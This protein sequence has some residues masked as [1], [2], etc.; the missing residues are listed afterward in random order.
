MR[1]PRTTSD[2]PLQPCVAA[3]L[4][5]VPNPP[6]QR[7]QWL[8]LETCFLQGRK[9]E[10]PWAS[11]ATITILPQALLSCPLLDLTALPTHTASAPDQTPLPA[12]AGA[13]QTPRQAGVS[14]YKLTTLRTGSGGLGLPQLSQEASLRAAVVPLGGPFTAGTHTSLRAA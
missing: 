3:F 4:M 9:P 11:S 2:G 7:T 1:A 6:T 13:G 14:H 10:T 5:R 8:I 12:L